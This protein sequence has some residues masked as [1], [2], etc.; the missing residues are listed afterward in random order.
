M[1]IDICAMYIQVVSSSGCFPGLVRRVL[2]SISL[3]RALFCRIHCLFSYLDAISN[4]KLGPQKSRWTD[5]LLSLF[6]LT[7]TR[8]AVCQI[9]WLFTRSEYLTIWLLYVSYDG[10]KPQGADPPIFRGD[11]LSSITDNSCINVDQ[12]HQSDVLVI[13]HGYKCTCQVIRWSDCCTRKPPC[14]LG[15]STCRWSWR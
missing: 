6:W 12:V 7:Y 1:P 10:T 8:H 3:H 5:E 13:Q 2:P 11:R 9:C 14:W 4:C 15:I